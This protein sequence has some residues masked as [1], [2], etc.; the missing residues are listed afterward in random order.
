MNKRE[1]WLD[2]GLA[3][4][5]INGDISGL[6]AEDLSHLDSEKLNGHVVVLRD[7]IEFR[8]CEVTRLMSDCILVSVEKMEKENE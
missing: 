1:F 2:R 6:N 8:R 7:E 5:C 3:V 4:A